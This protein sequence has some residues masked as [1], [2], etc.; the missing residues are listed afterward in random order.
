MSSD[1]TTFTSSLTPDEVLQRFESYA[2][3]QGW[4]CQ[5]H[6]NSGAEAK[7]GFTFRSFGQNI[8]LF[9]HQVGDGS[10]INLAAEAPQLVDWG[11]GNDILEG[12]KAVLS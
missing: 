9:V 3:A 1:T 6:G 10:E 8:Q 4:S 7:Q 2:R 11:Q 5:R 12:I